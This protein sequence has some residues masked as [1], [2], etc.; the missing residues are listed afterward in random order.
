QAFFTSDGRAVVTSAPDGTWRF[1]DSA[2]AREQQ[3][4]ETP[5]DWGFIIRRSHDGRTAYLSSGYVS[6]PTRVW[7]LVERKEVRKLVLESDGKRAQGILAISPNDKMLVVSDF[8]NN[9]AILLLDSQSG[10]RIRSLQTPG[11]R[12]FG[13]AFAPDGKTLTIWCEGDTLQIWDVAT[14]GKLRQFWPMG[15]PELR[16]G[17]PPNRRAG[18]LYSHFHAAISPDANVLVYQRMRVLKTDS[19]NALVFYD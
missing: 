12:P 13:A 14:G 5:E 19:P 15:E 3:R 7:D 6:G 4:I 17:T 16:E 2:T 18:V 10:K 9:K 1:W 8:D 11:P